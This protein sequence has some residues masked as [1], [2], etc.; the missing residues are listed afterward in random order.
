MYGV[1]VLTPE[2]QQ[3]TLVLYGLCCFVAHYEDLGFGPWEPKGIPSQ[4]LRGAGEMLRWIILVLSLLLIGGIGAAT[5]L[6][7]FAGSD[8]LG[9]GTVSQGLADAF[10][11]PVQEVAVQLGWVV[12]ALG[13]TVGI[14]ATARNVRLLP[15][16]GG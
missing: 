14:L 9:G 13:L 11:D 2:L 10:A 8:Q 5:V 4:L 12:V 16:L 15:S 7:E 1:D 6:D 3:G